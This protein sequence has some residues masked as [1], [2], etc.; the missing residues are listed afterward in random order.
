MWLEYHGQGQ[1]E[2]DYGEMVVQANGAPENP[3]DQTF[4]RPLI[5]KNGVGRAQARRA[6][7]RLG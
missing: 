3:R 5:R 1:G 4:S 2:R 6:H 7:I